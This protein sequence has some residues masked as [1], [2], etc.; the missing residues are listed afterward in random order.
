[1]AGSFSAPRPNRIESDSGF[2]VE[3]LGRTGMRYFE[4]DR[5]AFIDSEVLAKPDAMALYQSSIRRWDPP[6][7]SLEV[8]E[9]DRR[10]IVENIRAAF[11]SQG[12]ELQ[13]I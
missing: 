10:R 8:D 6:H 4:G 12:Y 13:V 1:M 11:E 5:S 9:E 3:V 2:A 7:E